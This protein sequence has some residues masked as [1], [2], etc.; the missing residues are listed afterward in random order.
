MIITTKNETTQLLTDIQAAEILNLSPQTLRN[1]R[2][3][4]SSNKPSWIKLGRAVRYRLSDIEAY[5]EKNRITV[6]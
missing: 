6:E 1:W 5:L 2:F 3:I 4:S